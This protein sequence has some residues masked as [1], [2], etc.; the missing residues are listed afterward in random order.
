MH[1]CVR[2]AA[3]AIGM[4]SHGLRVACCDAALDPA[5]QVITVTPETAALDAAV[6][7]AREGIAGVGVVNNLSGALIG[8]F[9]FSDLRCA[10]ALPPLPLL[11]WLPWLPDFATQ[12]GVNAG[13]QLGWGACG[14]GDVAH[15]AQLLHCKPPGICRWHA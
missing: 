11:A 2:V 15:G 5:G 10:V 12:Q 8:N 4:I 9:S 14:A 13:Q 7:M 6:L 1:A 3:G